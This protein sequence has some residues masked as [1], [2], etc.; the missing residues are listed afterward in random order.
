MAM[1]KSKFIEAGEL[2]IH[3]LEAGEGVP[4]IALHGGPATAEMTWSEN[5]RLAAHHHLYSPDSRGHGQTNNP[6]GTLSYAQMADDVSAF[7]NALGLD[8][9]MIFGYSDGAQTALEFG[10]RHSGE[11]RALV[12]GGV[13]TEASPEYLAGIS[14]WGFVVPGEVDFARLE[15]AWGDFYRSFPTV[16]GDGWRDLLIQI[17]HL[18]IN[19]PTYADEQLAAIAEPTL[20]I[21]GDHDANGAIQAAPR[22]LQVLPR[23]ELA[24]IPN[25]DHGVIQN[26]LFWDSVLD[27]LARHA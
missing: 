8:R 21:C 11:A 7:I 17:S 14:D 16:H 25:A 6:A 2:R 24:V 9:P 10:I 5:E 23:A 12:L 1:P 3:Y 19:V 27:F 13:V 20:V 4:V 26:P 22:L 18:W 15:S